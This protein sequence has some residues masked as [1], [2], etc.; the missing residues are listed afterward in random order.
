M[1]RKLTGGSSVV[2]R[3][4]TGIPGFDKLCQGGLVRHNTYVVKGGPGAGKTI[5]L[6]QFLW[7]GL[8]YGENGL[9]L[10]FESDLFDV[11]QDAYVM[12]WDFSKYDQQGKCKFVRFDP[13]ITEREISKQIMDLVS[14]Y[15]I[16]RICMDPVSV[17]SMSIGD[18]TKIRKTLYNL[19]SLMK[20][21]RATVLLS[22]ETSGDAS[23]DLAGRSLHDIIDFLVD[24]VIELHSVGIGGEADR[25]VRI[26]KM[27]RTNHVREPI[28][29]KI[30]NNGITVLA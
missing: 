22:N 3:C 5:F 25:A 30:T 24:G 23:G 17:F 18:E 27:R 21:L 13:S 1:P 14:K 9:Y 7:N 19:T 26:V 28:P 6:L 20:R 15:E 4:P 8:M 10:S 2:E 12:G 29:M 11:M 16:K